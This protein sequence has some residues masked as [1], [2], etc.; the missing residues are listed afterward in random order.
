MQIENQLI[1]NRL[2]VRSVSENFTFQLFM[3][4][5]L[6]TREIWYSLKK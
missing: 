5:Q 6:Y 2:R 4:L 1:N 3:I